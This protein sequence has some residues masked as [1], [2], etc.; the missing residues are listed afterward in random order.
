VTFSTSGVFHE[1]TSTGTLLR[2]IKTSGAVGY[3]EHRGTLYGK[4]PPYDK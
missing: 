2:E 1:I 3:S 4:P